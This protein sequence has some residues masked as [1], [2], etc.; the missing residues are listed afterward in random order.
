MIDKDHSSREVKKEK[1]CGIDSTKNYI[2]VYSELLKT[3]EQGRN[4]VKATIIAR[5]NY[6]CR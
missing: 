1:K 5:A 3:N 4:K 2:I 6:R